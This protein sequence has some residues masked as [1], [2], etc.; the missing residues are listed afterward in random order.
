MPR[1]RRGGLV[2]AGL[3]GLLVLAAAAASAAPSDRQ[4]LIEDAREALGRGDGLGAEVRLKQALDAGAPRALVAAWMGEAMLQQGENAKARDWLAPGRFD[5]AQA[6]HGWHMLALLEHREGHLPAAAAAYDKALALAPR[7]PALW[8]DLGRMRYTS[9]DHMLALEAADH[10]L[11]LDPRSVR[12]LEFKGQ[13]VRDQF[14]LAAALPWF[15]QALAQDPG[16]LSVMGEYAATLGDL[17]LG[18]RML[19]VTREMLKRDGS[20]AR[21]FFLQAQL[22]ARAGDMSLARAMLNKTGDRLKGTPARML[23]DGVIELSAGNNLLAIEALE[24]LVARQPANAEAQAL[25][26]RAYYANGDYKAVVSRFASLA[27][28]GDARSDLL[29]TVARAYEALGQRDLAVPLL[30]RA[31]RFADRPFAPVP[32]NQPIG[33]LLAA[34]MT[35]QAQTQAEQIRQGNPGSATAQVQ[36]GDALM[37]GGRGLEAI[38]RYVMAARIRVPDSLLARVVAGYVMAGRAADA[39]GSIDTWL[40]RNPG[41]RTA[42]RLAAWYAAGTGNWSRARHLLEAVR[43]SGSESD[44]RLLTDLAMAQLKDGDA[45]A[46]EATAR[47]AYGLQPSNGAA[48]GAWG[49]SLNALKSRPDDARAL[50]AKAKLLGA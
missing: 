1:P 43:M 3:A 47:M 46:A 4:A 41:N 38:E 29:A 22:A 33:A 9:G 36:A 8:V 40:A 16:D 34:G 11:S 48:A 17:G 2:V 27:A 26:G 28:R 39:G 45:Q 6:A 24:Q 50:L 37:A 23:L 18:S 15:E 31:A 32:E 49:L 44:V 19:A 25:L 5:T 42:M 20:N 35:G 12:A 7:D 30:E 13:F 21:A 14:G 10:A